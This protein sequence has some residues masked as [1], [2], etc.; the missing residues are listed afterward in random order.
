MNVVLVSSSYPPPPDVHLRSDFD[1]ND[2]SPLYLQGGI[3]VHVAQL[4]EALSARGNSVKVFAWS[5]RFDE[6]N[7]EGGVTVC[8]L[9]VPH[10]T[11]S[12]A[13][14]TPD[15]IHVL[16]KRFVDRINELILQPA[17]LPDVI[18]CHHSMAF[19]AAAGLRQVTKA[20]LISTAH[21]LMCSPAFPYAGDIPPGTRESEQNMCLSSDHVIAV[22]R[23]VRDSIMEE[24]R[25]PADRI[26]VVHNGIHTE[27]PAFDPKILFDWRTRFTP[28]REKVIA[29]A[30][31]LTAEK[32]ITGFIEAIRI[33]LRELPSAIVLIAGGYS[34][35]IEALKITLAQ[36]PLLSDH[37]VFLGWVTS[38]DLQYLR[39]LAD[40]IVIPSLYDPFPYAALESM[41]AGVPIVCSD[42]GGL[43]EMIEDGKTGLVVPLKHVGNRLEVDTRG[44]AQAIATL[45]KDEALRASLATAAHTRAMTH[46]N[47]Q[48]MVSEIT[49]LYQA[50]DL[51]ECSL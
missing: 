23:W 50:R 32:G 6:I 16:E 1:P 47:T 3:A 26:S 48:T 4:A 5:P 37:V 20:R 45:L 22:S 38:S 36:E 43:P 28:N 31:R 46:F 9:S 10:R 8:R 29:Y 12:S 35:E 40:V 7:V 19:P 24:C 25:V 27:P 2:K 14:P 42:A 13:Y 34:D 44:F 39:A 15:E 30:G 17:D 11:T 41:A 49:S 33:V 18:H 21:I 51:H